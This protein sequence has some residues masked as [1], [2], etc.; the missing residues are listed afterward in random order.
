MKREVR[1]IVRVCFLNVPEK[2]IDTIYD[3]IPSSSSP[4]E[5]NKEVVI[6]KSMQESREKIKQN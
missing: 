6:N 4:N 2:S 5:L 1:S 3:S